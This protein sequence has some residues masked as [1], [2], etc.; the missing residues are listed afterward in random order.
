MVRQNLFTDTYMCSVK[1]SGN[2]HKVN[3][4]KVSSL[5]L[6]HYCSD[7]VQNRIYKYSVIEHLK[8]YHWWHLFKRIILWNFKIGWFYQSIPNTH[9][10]HFYTYVVPVSLQLWK[11]LTLMPPPQPEVRNWNQ[12]SPASF[13]T[14]CLHHLTQFHF[15]LSVLSFSSSNQKWKTKNSS[16]QPQLHIR[17]QI[18]QF[19]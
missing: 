18:W 11:A 15:T 19:Y 6:W 17:I 16:R 7:I 14:G 9:D 1:L 5:V 8:R 12:F 13:N 4:H 3:T 2:C 10:P